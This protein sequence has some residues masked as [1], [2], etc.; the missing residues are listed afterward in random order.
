MKKTL[1]TSL[2]LL[3][4]TLSHQA[5]ANSPYDLTFDPE[6]NYSIKTFTLDNISY[7]V[8]AYE[9][10]VYVANPIDAEYEKLNVYIPVEYFDNKTINGYS[11]QT[12]PIFF[13]NGVGGY[14]PA[15]PMVLDQNSNRTS[16][17]QYAIR[18]GLVV[19][20][21][22]ARGR[23]LENAQKQ[24]T[25]KAPAAIVDLKAAVA[26]LKANDDKMFGDANKII[27]NGT[28]AGAALSVL[29][30]ASANSEDYQ[31]Y[32]NELGAAKADDRIFAASAYAPITNLENADTAYEW[33]FQGVNQY[34]AININMLDYHVQRS[35]TDGTL[36]EQQIEVSNQLAAAFPDYVNSLNLQDSHHH[37]LSLDKQG[38]GTFKTFLESYLQQS[39]QQALSAGKTVD[40]QHY[41]WLQ[42]ENGKVSQVDLATYAQ[43]V[44]RQ[45]TPP[46]F[47]ALD[48]SAGENDE[49]GDKTTQAKHFTEYS[50][51]HSQV[52][53]AKLADKTIVK[54]MNP[55][56]YIDRQN[57]GVAQH[58]RIRQGTL[59]KDTSLAI[60]LILATKLSNL[61]YQVDYA[62]AWDQ[63]HS[64]DYD[65][66]Q[67]FEWI[68]NISK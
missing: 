66:P 22:G 14:M 27:A 28:S 7:Q 13:P 44:V 29:L 12:A 46:A 18:Q 9:N 6:Q 42:V 1:L 17:M 61:G 40:H 24:Y 48:L 35:Y 62:L 51:Q 4:A 56:N 52:A 53:G 19:V 2:L 43:T 8:R 67:L 39:A 63:P 49:F 55:M 38:H 25:G 30:A 26:Y 65:L 54:M 3:S 37:Q 11:A 36:N 5:F 50:M 21:A 68:D 41:P 58:W 10:I 64:G 15:K 20:S 32:L 45:K 57:V 16:A 31:P 33:L 23:T 34:K 60:P 47:D 59:D